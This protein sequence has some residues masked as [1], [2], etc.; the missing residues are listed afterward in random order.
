MH[1]V[2]ALA[3]PQGLHIGGVRTALFNWLLHV[4]GAV[5]SFYALMTRINSALQQNIWN[6]FWTLFAG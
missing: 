3:S 2:S 6:P 1:S 5:S 4:T